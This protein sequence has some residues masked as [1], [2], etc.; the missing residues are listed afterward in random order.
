MMSCPSQWS[1]S[2]L[3]FY[4][5]SL[6]S[7][8]GFTRP[9]STA[10]TSRKNLDRS[11][12]PSRERMDVDDMIKPITAANSSGYLQYTHK[13]WV[14]ITIIELNILLKLSIYHPSKYISS[15]VFDSLKSFMSLYYLN[16]LDPSYLMM[17]E[18]LV[19][20]SSIWRC[21]KTCKR[22]ERYRRASV[23]CQPKLL[24]C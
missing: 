11:S 22:E 18:K 2:W 10:I 1:E 12:V 21:W 9:W 13:T 3:M 7:G 20:Y 4:N 23:G 15:N 19:S 17:H 8:G 24:W 14:I 6:R 16:Q 5:G